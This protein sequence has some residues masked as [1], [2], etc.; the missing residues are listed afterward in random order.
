VKAQLESELTTTRAALSEYTRKTTE[1]EGAVERSKRE[2]EQQR[3]DLDKARRS[4][5]DRGC[6]CP[7]CMGSWKTPD[8]LHRHMLLQCHKPP[9]GKKCLRKPPKK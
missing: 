7:V 1:L 4:A 9:C 3:K 6:L 8:E 5:K 2:I